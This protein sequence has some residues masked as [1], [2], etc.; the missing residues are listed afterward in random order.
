MS[1]TNKDK[2]SSAAYPFVKWAGGK[3]QLLNEISRIYSGVLGTRWTKYAE[4]FVGGGAVL[5]DILNGYE[6]EDVYIGDTNR[7]LILTYTTIRDSPQQ[8]VDKLKML[9]DTFI[10]MSLENR[11]LYYYVIRNDFNALKKATTVTDAVELASLFIFLN[12]TC[13]NGLYRVNS[14]GEYNVSMGDY[15]NPLICDTENLFNV[16]NKLKNVQIVCADYKQSRSFI[17]DKTFVYFDPPYRPL[18]DTSNFTSFTQDGF[19]DDSQREL[20]AFIEELNNLSALIVVSNSEPK[21]KNEED[22]FF[23]NL[24]ADY[25]INRVDATR[26][27]NSKGSARGQIKELLITNFYKVQDYI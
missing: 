12:K 21:N 26:R 14:S 5:F 23:D 17:D 2:S 27:I 9:Q 7:E 16:S 1:K 10:P 4:P 11:K 18:S 22:H 15:K 25:Q 8:L 6:L 3:G 20:A 13:F 19:N 24:Y